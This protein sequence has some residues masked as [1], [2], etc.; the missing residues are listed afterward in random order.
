M[1]DETLQRYHVRTKLCEGAGENSTII[2]APSNDDGELYIAI[3]DWIYQYTEQ[4]TGDRMGTILSEVIMDMLWSN[5][6]ISPVTE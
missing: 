6:V 3:E 1:F 4:L 2:F 5:L